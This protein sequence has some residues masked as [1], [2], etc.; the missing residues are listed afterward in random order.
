M[1]YRA[2][3]D[4]EVEDAIDERELPAESDMDADDEPALVPC[5]YCREEIF[6]DV[7][8][9]AHCGNYISKEDMA[10]TRSRVKTT[11]LAVLVISLIGTV[12]V[13]C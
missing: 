10:W 12:L 6:D 5:P 4:D 2:E 3:D 11:A 8:V 1:A 13:S 7:E 9:C